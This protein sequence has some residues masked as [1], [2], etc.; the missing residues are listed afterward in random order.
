MHL[1]SVGIIAAVLMMSFAVSAK[2]EMLVGD[3]IN[4]EKV[5]K[6][7]TQCHRVGNNAKTS[8]GPILNNVINAKAA[9]KEGFNYSK[10]MKNAG[11]DGLVW[12]AE[13]LNRYLENPR[14]MIP[15]TKMMFRGLK[16]AQDRAD[17]IV[18]LT[19]FSLVSSSEKAEDVFAV[20]PA[21]LAIEGD[22]E[23]GEYL[24]SGCTACH[25]QSGNAD[26]IPSIV[27]WETEDFVTAMHAYRAKHRDNP[28]MQVVAGYLSDEEIA[29]LAA[30]FKKLKKQ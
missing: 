8:A 25:Q 18:Y 20:S 2:A 11:E 21:V 12:T 13:N 28:V 26:G 16:K 4:G 10:A 29:A 1:R 3:A 6:K 9:T 30:Y 14:K 24:S 23:Y 19:Q 7:C 5:F 15:K 22:I 27:G 17:V